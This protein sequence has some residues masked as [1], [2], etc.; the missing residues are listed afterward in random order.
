MPPP[1]SR[2]RRQLS[3][4]CYAAPA[5]RRRSRTPHPPNHRPPTPPDWS[6]PMP[7]RA[8]STP[9]A[10]AALSE[11]AAVAVQ[12]RRGGRNRAGI[13]GSEQR[14]RAPNGRKSRDGFGR[15]ERA[16]PRDPPPIR[17][18]ARTRRGCGDR[19][20]RMR[21]GICGSKGDWGFG[22]GDGREIGA[23]GRSGR[24]LK[25]ISGRRATEMEGESGDVRFGWLL[26][27][28]YLRSGLLV[29]QG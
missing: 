12:T 24:F 27:I 9:T 2:P 15:G 7:R 18:S 17:R 21:E 13:S 3:S 29:H 11:S 20:E 4:P 6:D 26:P 25:F 19:P 16:P 14:K 10:T 22:G 1:P 8:N 5:Q 28:I 23:R